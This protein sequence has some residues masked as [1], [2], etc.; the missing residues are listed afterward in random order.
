[1]SGATSKRYPV[2][3]RERAVR[4]VGEIRAD[5]ESEWAAMTQVAGLLGIGTPETV[6]KWGRPLRGH[7]S[8]ACGLIVS[9]Y[10]PTGA[11]LQRASPP[12]PGASTATGVDARYTW[13][14]ERVGR[15]GL[16]S[17]VDRRRAGATVVDDVAVSRR[18]CRRGR[19]ARMRPQV[20]QPRRV[21]CRA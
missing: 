17:W 18:C 15:W 10:R 2:E 21:W 12:Y 11:L 4:M 20:P 13:C 16:H 1:M 8:P 6:R 3:L 19:G 7:R 14:P 5:H 9:R